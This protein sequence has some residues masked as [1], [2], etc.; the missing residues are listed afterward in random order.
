MERVLCGREERVKRVTKQRIE[1]RY[2]LEWKREFLREI[3]NLNT[4]NNSTKD[5]SNNSISK[6]ITN[7][8]V[9][10]KDS[11]DIGGNTKVNYTKVNL[12]LAH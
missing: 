9:I 5:I 12:L 7:N 10:T 8:D 6:D 3:S 4:T 1:S 2:D 11:I